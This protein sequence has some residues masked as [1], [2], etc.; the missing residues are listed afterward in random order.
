M[1]RDICHHPA[2]LWHWSARWPVFGVIVALAVAVTT[3]GEYAIGVGLILLSALSLI[4]KLWHGERGVFLRFIGTFGIALGLLVALAIVWDAKAD[5]PWSRLPH[6]WARLKGRQ[7]ESK[8]QQA[9]KQEDK[10]TILVRYSLQPLPIEIPPRSS[11]LVLQLTPHIQYQTMEVPNNTNHKAK[12]PPGRPPEIGKDMPFG[13]VYACEFSNHG[14]KALLDVEMMFDIKFLSVERTPAWVNANG[15]KSV[16]M[17]TTRK[18]DPMSFVFTDA[19]KRV[20][21]ATSGRLVS[22]HMHR[23]T[24]PVISARDTVTVYLVSQSALFSQFS[25]PSTATLVVD[26]NPTHR[27]GALIRPIMNPID[28]IPKWGLSPSVYRWPNVPDSALNLNAFVAKRR[29]TSYTRHA[30]HPTS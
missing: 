17:D 3:I 4:S 18:D 10:P 25:L 13:N 16:Q 11:I 8:E 2:R 19:Q 30:P 24:I 28:S 22:E 7:K 9:A 12:W 26:G 21:A 15:T 1:L 20:I 6:A 27:V 14:D 29:S 5:S 23:A